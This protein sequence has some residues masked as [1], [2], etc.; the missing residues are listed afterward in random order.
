LLQHRAESGGV[1]TKGRKYGH[2]KERGGKRD[3]GVSSVNWLPGKRQMVRQ[4]QGKDEAQSVR[5]RQPSNE[6]GPSRDSGRTGVVGL[7]PKATAEP[8]DAFRVAR[9]GLQCLDGLEIA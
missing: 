8:V 4:N 6:S 5:D 9:V 1:E 3:K 7:E 2:P